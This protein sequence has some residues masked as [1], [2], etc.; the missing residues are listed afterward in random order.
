[1]AKAILYKRIIFC[2]P[3]CPNSGYI[4]K[5]SLYFNIQSTLLGHLHKSKKESY[6]NV[7]FSI[8]FNSFFQI[9]KREK[10]NHTFL[11]C[12]LVQLTREESPNKIRPQSS[13]FIE[14]EGEKLQIFVVINRER[15]GVSEIWQKKSLKDKVKRK[16][17]AWSLYCC[18]IQHHSF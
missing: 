7:L 17:E 8:F 10:K 9:S 14:R 1:M 15:K 12:I 5:I 13:Q 16:V 6:S 3:Y 4:C 2:F 18:F 11:S